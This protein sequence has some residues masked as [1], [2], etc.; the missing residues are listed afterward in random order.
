VREKEWRERMDKRP[1]AELE[2]NDHPK[3]ELERALRDVVDETSRFFDSLGRAVAVTAQDLTKLMV[4]HV[5]DETR[6][7][8]DLLVDAELA[9]NRHEAA[10]AMLN[11]GIEAKSELFDRIRRTKS[12]IAD[13]RDQMR[14]L[15]R[16]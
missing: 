5:D 13:L 6:E 11:E 8:L 3:G 15:V 9:K 1:R 10:V 4:I 7:H 2:R 14:T 12:Q 16:T